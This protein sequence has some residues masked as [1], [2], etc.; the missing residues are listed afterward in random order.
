MQVLPFNPSSIPARPAKS[1]AI[2]PY[3]WQQWQGEWAYWLC[4]DTLA[5]ALDHAPRDGRFRL[6]GPHGILQVLG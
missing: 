6:V 3:K 1:S 2:Y 5:T 4:C